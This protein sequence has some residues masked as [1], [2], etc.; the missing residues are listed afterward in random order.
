MS[1]KVFTWHIS[2]S[3]VVP[4][5]QTTQV[6]RVSWSS[7]HI[8]HCISPYPFYTYEQCP[9]PMDPRKRKMRRDRKWFERDVFRT[10]GLGSQSSEQIDS[11]T[12][13][14]VNAGDHCERR[15]SRHI[16]PFEL[17]F[18]WKI[19]VVNLN[20][21]TKVKFGLSKIYL[22]DFWWFK[23]IISREMNW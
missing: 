15:I 22:R 13:E 16:A 12:L 19:F 21:Q 23:W 6:N 11:N 14:I 4:S 9:V 10:S 17:I 8:P 3:T 5:K 20:P 18:G 2:E 1:R 7:F